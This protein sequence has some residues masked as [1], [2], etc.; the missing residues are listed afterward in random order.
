MIYDVVLVD[1]THIMNENNLVILDNSDELIYVMTNDMVN[2]KNMKSVVTILKEMKLKNY[3]IVLN[4]SMHSESYFSNLDIKNIINDSVDYVI[5]ASYKIKNI[6]SVMMTGKI[7]T[8][9]A[10]LSNKYKKG[11]KVI[12]KLAKTLIK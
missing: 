4:E 10:K 7:V 11:I 2:I 3:K 9:D 1:T 12:S 8:L 6:D 5:P